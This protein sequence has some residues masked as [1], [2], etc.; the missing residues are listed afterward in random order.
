MIEGRQ[1]T[2]YLAA[3]PGSP[4]PIALNGPFRMYRLAKGNVGAPPPAAKAAP[5]KGKAKK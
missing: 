5:K 3:G 1:F 2:G 4:I